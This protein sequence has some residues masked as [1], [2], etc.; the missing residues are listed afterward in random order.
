MA[1]D[2]S[3]WTYRDPHGLR[4]F[5]C[6]TCW[7]ITFSLDPTPSQM[8]STGRMD[9]NGHPR[10]TPGPRQRQPLLLGHWRWGVSH[11]RSTKV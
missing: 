1:G 5:C 3:R 10:R 8:A 9:P 4:L 11:E 6:Y 2:C 7:A